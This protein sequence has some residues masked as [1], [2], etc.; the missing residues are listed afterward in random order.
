MD[1]SFAPISGVSSDRFN[2]V[3][4]VVGNRRRGG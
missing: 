3:T 4:V 2:I 1:F